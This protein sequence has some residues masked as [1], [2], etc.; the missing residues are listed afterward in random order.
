[1]MLATHLTV[2]AL[3]GRGCANPAVAFLVGIASH[4]LLDVLPHEDAV[5]ARTELRVVAVLTPAIAAGTHFDS[6]ALA[7][8]VGGALPDLEHIQRLPGAGGRLVFPTHGPGGFHE[9]VPLPFRFSARAQIAGAAVGFALLV[10][11]AR[12]RLRAR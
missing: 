6:R 9:V 3:A 10:V 8:A 5:T 12:A 2:G 1:M 7:G 4:A 11:G